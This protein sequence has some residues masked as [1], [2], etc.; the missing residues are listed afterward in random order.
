MSIKLR[1]KILIGCLTVTAIVCLSLAIALSFEKACGPAKALA[2][3]G[4]MIKAIM[5]RCYGSPD[6]LTFEDIV[7]PMP[8]DDEMLIKVRAAA[9]NPVDWHTLR[10]SPYIMRLD[11]GFGAPKHPR[12]GVDFAGVVE[13][14]GKNVTQYKPGDAIF[15]GKTGAFAEYVVVRKDGAFA[16]K[17]SNVSFEQAAAVPVA[18][19]TALQA[20]RDKGRV[21]PGQKVLINGASG[22]VGTFAV[23]IARSF[24][25][26]VTGVCSTRNM[27]LVRSLGAD[28]VI[29]YT[30]TDFTGEGQRYDLI[31]DNV[32]NH[33]I[34]EYRRAMTP[35]GILVI[36]GGP[37]DGNWLGP[38]AGLIK[39]V[40]WSPF[41]S[42]EIVFI[43]AEFKREDLATLADLMQSGKLSSV[44]DRSYSLQETPDAIRYL[45][46]GHARGKVVI[47]M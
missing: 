44:I 16:L 20:L 2:G 33:S 19:I 10:G 28:H 5:H 40:M 8:T 46:A 41:V 26:E 11:A 38:L 12:L 27:D 13:A 36:I 23:Q 39:A 43:L 25:A 37:S 32:G 24:G 4:T 3:G 42:Q 17:P 7:K 21:Q 29:D 45:E 30:N 22:G 9:V 15:G 34:P 31:L 6:V 1:Y 18:A 35:N 47:N 14:V